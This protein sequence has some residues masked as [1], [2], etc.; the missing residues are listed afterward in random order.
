MNRMVVVME[1]CGRR[2]RGAVG[3][4]LHTTFVVVEKA[5]ARLGWE[6]ECTDGIDPRDAGEVLVECAGWWLVRSG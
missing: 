4:R 2:V 1:G 3:R 5:N 6:L